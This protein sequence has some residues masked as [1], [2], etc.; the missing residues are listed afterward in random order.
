M[1]KLYTPL[2]FSVIGQKDNQE[3][4]LFPVPSDIKPTDHVF[5][6]CDG[7]GGHENGEVASNCVAKTIG[8]LMSAE[9]IADSDVTKT[10]FN[11]ALQR[12]YAELDKLDTSESERKM[13]TTLTF[14]AVCTDG[15]LIAHI[16]DS[17]VYQFRDGAIIF[18][19]RDHSLVNDLVAAGEITPEEALTHPKRNVITRAVQ[20]HQEYPARATFDVITDVEK[21][22]VFF[23]C[24]D[25]VIEQVSDQELVAVLMDSSKS[26]VDALAQLEQICAVRGTRDNHTC[27]LLQVGEVQLARPVAIPVPVNGKKRPAPKS[28]PTSKKSTKVMV[29]YILYG[30]ILVLAIVIVAMCLKFCGKSSSEQFKDRV[31][32]N[33]DL[34]D[35]AV[36]VE[37][38]PEEEYYYDERRYAD[39]YDEDNISRPAPSRDKQL[40]NDEVTDNRKSSTPIADTKKSESK[41]AQSASDKTKDAAVK[42]GKDVIKKEASPS[43]EKTSA[44]NA[45]PK[46]DE[47]AKPQ[48][49]PQPKQEQPTDPK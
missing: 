6:V 15:V 14:F 11:A 46:T 26:K 3:D 38:F 45:A 10:K 35:S 41:P 32:G 4:A 43:P 20:P 5:M 30:A 9:S 12:A 22:D 16:G 47:A 49:P 7:M 44:D 33:S 21:D 2:S 25:G 24:S 31:I 27:Y 39:N 29:N 17:R 34:V 19:T 1:I 42:L 36:P 23:L 18:C 13:G 40:N 37:S 8:S 28:G 48:T